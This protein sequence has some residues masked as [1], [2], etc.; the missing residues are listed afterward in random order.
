M[1][2]MLRSMAKA[3]M[4]KN[5]TTKIN[6]RMSDGRWRRYV[7]AYPVN[8]I[9]GKKMPN[10]FIGSKK[11]GVDHKVQHRKECMYSYC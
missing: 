4:M 2:K 11:S 1:R 7:N 9:T 6:K 8:A 3:R 5:G 10:T